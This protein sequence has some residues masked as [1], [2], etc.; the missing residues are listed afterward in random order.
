MIDQAHHRGHARQALDETIAMDHAVAAVIQMTKESDTLVI[1]TADHDQ[2]MAFTGY[3]PREAD[4]LG[5]AE[6]SKIDKIP[7]TSL[8]YTTG[9][10]SNFQF[11][12]DG[13][14]VQRK[15][16]KES[17]TTSFEYSQQ[18]GI[19]TDEVHHSGSDVAIYARGPMAHLFSGV[20][21]Q[22]FVPFVVAY[23]AQI[24]DYKS[25]SDSTLGLH[26]LIISVLTA[27]FV[28]LARY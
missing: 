6:D 17:D 12:T 24:G 1:V 22:N 4:I 26:H 20:H 21:E 8:L 15:S 2:G 27:T 28:L 13:K 19:L 7:F 14:T 16:P 23:A 5:I 11:T 9:D 3:A 18:T 10:A 25:G